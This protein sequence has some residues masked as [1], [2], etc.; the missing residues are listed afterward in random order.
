MVDDEC[1]PMSRLLLGAGP[2]ASHTRPFLGMGEVLIARGH[3][4]AL[5][6][7][8][9]RPDF[10]AAGF[11]TIQIDLVGA[12]PES[13]RAEGRDAVSAWR[14][15]NKIEGSAARVPSVRAMLERYRPEAIAIDGQVLPL[16]IAAHHL[17]IPY[18]SVA[19]NLM[20]HLHEFDCDYNTFWAGL[21]PDLCAM[22]ADHGMTVEFVG[23]ELLSPTWNITFATEALVGHTSPPPGGVL[24][25]PTIPPAFANA[26]PSFPWQA[27]RSDRP[28]VYTACGSM[29]EWPKSHIV[30]IA[31]ATAN[32]G[33]QLVLASRDLAGTPF[34][35]S[36][37]GDVLAVGFAP[38][39]DLLQRVAACVTHAGANTVMEASRFGV[40]LLAIP[41]EGDAPANADA[42]VRASSG[43][44]VPREQVDA[45]RLTEALRAVLDDTGPIRRGAAAVHAS[46]AARDGSQVAASLLEGLA[47]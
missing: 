38:Q 24:A 47:R 23:S 32:C 3:E 31:E 18:L 39:V 28:I 1:G 44:S 29:M 37:P 5:L 10:E 16:Y 46:Y 15:H 4:V 2:V 17:G 12:V 19:T 7:D 43:V 9:P 6:V 41:L 30:A 8:R 27:L 45:A 33:A 20:F 14:R 42:I 35:A 21:R 11:K 25:G 26:A 40:P 13:V 34:V 22:F 36:L